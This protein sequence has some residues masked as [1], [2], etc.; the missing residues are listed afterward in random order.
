MG[1]NFALVAANPTAEKVEATR[2]A[3]KFF[4]WAFKKG[5]AA[6]NELGYA[7]IPQSAIASVE[8]AWRQAK[9]PS[10]RPIWET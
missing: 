8:S 5:A 9:D 2:N 4:D 1:A 6:A 7:A 10:G 3:F